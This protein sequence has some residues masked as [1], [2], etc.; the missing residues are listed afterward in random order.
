MKKNVAIGVG[1]A[2]A[3]VVIGGGTAFALNGMGGGGS[4]NSKFLQYNQFGTMACQVGNSMRKTLHVDGRISDV[5]LLKNT[6]F[7]LFHILDIA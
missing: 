2:A 7:K 6:Y 1:I 3:V 5:M 4:A